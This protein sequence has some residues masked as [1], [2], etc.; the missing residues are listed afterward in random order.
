MKKSSIKFDLRFK[1]I[2]W[3]VILIQFVLTSIYYPVWEL[4]SD[5]PMLFNNAAYHLY[6][7][8]F[9]R[10][11]AEQSRI[12]GYDPSF[13]A[14][15]VGGFTINGSAKVVTL[16]AA[17]LHPWASEVV[18]YKVYAYTCDFLGPIFL[19]FALRILRFGNKEI[20]VG[21][22]LGLIL[23]WASWFRWSY[24]TGMG[25]SVLNMYVAVLYAALV[26]RYL[27]GDWGAKFPVLAGLLAAFLFF[28]HPHFLLP[29]SL[30]TAL[31]LMFSWRT[32]SRQRA[33]V[34]LTIIPVFAIL[35]NLPWLIAMTKYGVF[36]EPWNFQNVVDASL[37]WK[38]AIGLY[39]RL[40]G[41][42]AKVYPV[43]WLGAI[44]AIFMTKDKNDR[45]LLLTL[46]ATGISLILLAR[47]GP[48]LEFLKPAELNRFSAVGYLFLLLP[49]SKGIV[50]IAAIAANETA[51][52][53]RQG[54]RASVAAIAIL[55]VY[56]TY[57]VAREVSW[58]D[59][60][61][62]G[63]HAPQIA[64]LSDDKAWLL[65][66]LTHN[67]DQSGRIL[68]ETSNLDKNKSLTSY[69]SYMSDLQFIG[70]PIP[71]RFRFTNP[72]D[73][74]FFDKNIEDI[75]PS[76]FEQYLD[77]YNI[78]WII[79]HTE[80]A[81]KQLKVIPS[82]RLTGEFQEYTAYHVDRPLN[83]FHQGRGVVTKAGANEL[84]LDHLEG[85]EIVLKYHYVNGLAADAPV[86]I[87]GVKL[88]DDPIP[89]IRLSGA[90]NH[91]TIYLP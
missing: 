6:Q 12:I 36:S 82:I 25:S 79:A 10:E 57:E 23:W 87:S 81:K 49:A 34:V 32:V 4:F 24:S 60:G 7:M 74:L 22:F 65:Q 85:D 33:L 5:L 28:F 88:L 67:A 38:D 70:G 16:I 35:P 13:V 56:G 14:G 1:G 45:R 2:F 63:I 37:I 83:Y 84:V 50:R 20:L 75:N 64:A 69:F 21:I 86:K 62:Y 76:Q 77:L 66:W 90:P 17:L 42:G 61:K 29:V 91:L 78:G 53:I 46:F 44:T 3:S 55:G 72:W 39:G 52:W 31:F 9:G 47:L 19:L 27:E 51:G 68:F 73:G 30:A 54:A 11:L 48:A 89:F 40:G 59:I 8:K 26:I 18:I 41:S 80:K 43:I 71:G 15:Y 58:M